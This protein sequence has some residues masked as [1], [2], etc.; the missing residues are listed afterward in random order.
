[1]A[2]PVVK[3]AGRRKVTGSTEGIWNL[4][5]LVSGL[6]VI[7]ILGA[8]LRLARPVL[9]PFFVALFLAFIVS[10]GLDFLTKL[11]VPRAA[12]IILIVL[13]TFLILY[14]LGS[15]FYTS[16]KGFAGEIS[17]Y[18]KKFQDLTQYLRETFHITS[19]EWDPLGWLTDLDTN[20]I[21]NFLLASIGPFFSFLANLLLVF[22]F[23][24]FILAGHGNLK[25]KI[26]VAYTR[27]Q[28]RQIR[29]IVD[30]ITG[31]VQR[32]LVIKTAV[33]LVAGLLTTAFLMVLGLDF[34]VIFGLLAFIM[35]YIPHLGAIFASALPALIAFV[36]FDSAAL[37][38][39]VLGV[40]YLVHQ[41]LGLLEVKVQGEGL[42]LSP[43]LVFFSLIFWGWLWG[44]PG[45][46][47]AVPI[48]AIIKIVCYNIPALKPLSLM[49]S[50]RA[51][52]INRS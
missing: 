17:K 30:H 47:L 2:K 9:F 11:K 32:Y 12:A 37:A 20:R 45:M 10:P 7:F 36:Q 46:I 51:E 4:N 5:L 19:L 16:G 6:I 39:L 13:I 27:E 31:Q 35:S 42:G 24:I 48:L 50:S 49:M 15:L 29:D 21:A 23:L 14:L 33:N 40:L 44:I 34:A 41:A 28:A 38:G 1:M 18:E 52:R 43:L 8:I 22:L 25:A 26:Q 3:S